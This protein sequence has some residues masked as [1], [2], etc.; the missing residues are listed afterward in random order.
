[1]E[2]FPQYWHFVRGI[3]QSPVDFLHGGHA[4]TQ[5]FDVFFLNLR[6]NKRLN[7]QSRRWWFETPLRSLWCHCYAKC[8]SIKVVCVIFSANVQEIMKE[9]IHIL[10]CY[11]INTISFGDMDCCPIKSN[12]IVWFVWSDQPIIERRLATVK[13]V[14]NA[15]S[16]IKY[17]TCDLFSNVF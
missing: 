2:T 10:F 13:P 5:S 16:I 7:K 9:I 3:H 4:V 8:Y 11:Y 17:I 12:V 15:T 1:M 6:L 14:C